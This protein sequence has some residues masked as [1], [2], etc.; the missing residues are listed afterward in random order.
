MKYWFRDFQK[1]FFYWFS[2]R[3]RTFIGEKQVFT[4]K[5][6]RH[7]VCRE[8]MAVQMRILSG[9]FLKDLFKLD[10]SPFGSLKELVQLE[11][12]L[13]F[14][15]REQSPSGSCHTNFWLLFHMHVKNLPILS[16]LGLIWCKILCWAQ[17]SI[18]YGVW[19]ATESHESPKTEFVSHE[20][21]IS[22]VTYPSIRNFML[23]SKKCTIWGLK[24]NRKPLEL[25]NEIC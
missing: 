24:S 6:V 16:F 10:T 15:P 5:K 14:W 4:K 9:G 19:N 25:K 20:I 8:F 13:Y 2:G 23:S 18:L 12:F 11:F 22:R 17:K 21:F 3:I 7:A 1:K